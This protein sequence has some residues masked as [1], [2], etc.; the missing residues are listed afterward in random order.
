KLFCIAPFKRRRTYVARH[1][2]RY[3]GEAAAFWIHPHSPLGYRK[4]ERHQRSA[5]LA[6]GGLRPAHSQWPRFSCDAKIQEQSFADHC[7]ECRNTEGSLLMIGC[8]F[9]QIPTYDVDR[10]SRKIVRCALV[11]DDF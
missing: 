9:S 2:E 8:R 3:R 10:R 5:A 7:V 11:G 1:D 4:L 6:F